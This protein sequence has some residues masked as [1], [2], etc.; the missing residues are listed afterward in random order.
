MNG[1]RLELLLLLVLALNLSVATLNILFEGLRGIRM[2][3]PG[4]LAWIRPSTRLQS[5]A[6]LLP[7]KISEL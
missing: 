3:H 4:R 2:R 1:I 5:A 7:V 6:V